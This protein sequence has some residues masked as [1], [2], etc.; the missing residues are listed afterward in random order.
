MSSVNNI[1]TLVDRAREWVLERIQ[2][3]R[4]WQGLGGLP[5]R[6]TDGKPYEGTNIPLLWKPWARLR[7]L[8]ARFRRFYVGVNRLRQG[9]RR[10]PPS[11]FCR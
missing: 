3:E 11:A 10:G 2:R 8:G 7:T 9:K 6:V 5:L 1:E 4:P